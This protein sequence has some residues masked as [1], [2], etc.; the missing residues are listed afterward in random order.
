MIVACTSVQ[1][2]ALHATWCEVI[3]VG[4]REAYTSY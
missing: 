3:T 2:E 4:A 1:V